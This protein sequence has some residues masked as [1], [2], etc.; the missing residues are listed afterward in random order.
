[1][2]AF[3]AHFKPS[4]SATFFKTPRNPEKVAKNGRFA[5]VSS[6]QGRAS[7]FKTPRNPGKVAKTGRFAL[8]SSCEAEQPSSKRPEIR[9]KRKIA[10]VFHSSTSSRQSKVPD[11]RE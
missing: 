7:F 9:E 3:C 1:L 8:V 10:G 5:L 6:L 4:G 2:W 11:M